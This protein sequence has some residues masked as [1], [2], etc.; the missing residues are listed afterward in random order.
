MQAKQRLRFSRK[1]PK[2]FFKTLNIRVNQYFKENKIEKTGNWKLY[3]KT[4]DVCFD[5]RT[6]CTCD[7]IKLKSLA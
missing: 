1:D 3:L 5:D 6:L 2:E 7:Y 4:I